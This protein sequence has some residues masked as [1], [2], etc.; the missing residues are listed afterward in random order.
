MRAIYFI[1]CMV[2]LLAFNEASVDAQVQRHSPICDYQTTLKLSKNHRYFI[3]QET[4][5]PFIFI[6][7][8]LWAM[9]RWTTREEVCQILDTIKSQGFTAIQLI[10][11]SHYYGKNKFGDLPFS[12]KNFCDPIITPGNN[13]KDTLAYDWWD[14]LDFIISQAELRGLFV[15]LLPSWREQWNQEKNLNPSNAFDYGVFIG[16]RF[17]KYNRK[18]IWILGGDGNSLDDYSRTIQKKLA[19]GITVGVTG[20]LDYSKVIFG[21]HPAGP[22]TSL[23]S[24]PKKNS[25]L[26]FNAVQSGHKIGQLDGLIEKVYSTTNKPVVNLEP[27]YDKG[28]STTN[29]VRTIIYWGIF[30]G[31]FGTSYGS[32]NVWHFGTH[33]KQYPFSI[34]GSFELGFQKQIKYL[35]QF[36]EIIPPN[37]EPN[38]KIIPNAPHKGQNRIMALTSG[39]KKTAIVYSPEGDAFSVDLSEI[40][41]I[42]IKYYWYDPR[43]GQKTKKRSMKNEGHLVK[44]SPPTKGKIYSGN[45]WILLINNK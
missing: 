21:Y 40:S 1:I 9:A 28:D 19:E 22:G 38:N 15:C 37:R 41:S 20:S 11:H 29:K 5:K 17:R 34:P 44:F 7:Q 27:F 33:S 26:D 31:G 12:N 4:G 16:S 10:A 24:F 39:D 36:L 32:W 43:N 35:H 23:M 14:H 45:D 25:I 3:N 8:T 6:S 13:P 42:R 2:G 18:I 30:A